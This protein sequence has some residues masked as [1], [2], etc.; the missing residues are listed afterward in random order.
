MSLINNATQQLWQGFMPRRSEIL[1]PS[2]ANY[3][4]IEVYPDG[5]FDEFSPA[6]E[7]EKWAAVQVD[8]L[9]SVPSGMETISIPVGDYAVF[10]YKGRPSQVAGFFQKLYSEWLP[11]SGYQLDQRPHFAIMDERYKGESDDSEEEFWIPV[12]K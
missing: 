12:R 11:K 5:Y 6:K 7:F 3:Y 9:D 10:H 1:K 8:N 2:N 4:S